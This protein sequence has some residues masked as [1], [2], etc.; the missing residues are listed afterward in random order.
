MTTKMLK[1]DEE[2]WK[3]LNKFLSFLQIEKGKRM[4]FADAIHYIVENY[5]SKEMETINKVLERRDL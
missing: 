1:V 3:V 4:S 2:D 5:V